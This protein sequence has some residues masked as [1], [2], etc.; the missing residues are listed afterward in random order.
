M[1]S[2]NFWLWTAAA[3]VLLLLAAS[4][5]GDTTP[6]PTLDAKQK[7]THSFEFRPGVIVDPDRPAVYLMNPQRGIDA[8]DLSSGKLICTTA[9]AAKPLFLYGDLL[10]AQAETS[11]RRGVLRI[12][13]LDAK[14]KGGLG[15]EAEIALP[16]GVWASIDDGLGTSFWASARIHEGAL[17]VSWFFA[18]QLLSGANLRPDATAPRQIT[19]AARIDLKTGR[20]ERLKADEL[21]PL[22]IAALPGNVAQLVASGVL[23]GPVWHVGGVAATIQRASDTGGQ[24]TIL[25]RWNLDTGEPLP[26]VVLFG[27]ELTFRYPSAN[28][29]H[30]LTSKLV[31]TDP[32]VKYLWVIFSLETGGRVAEVR[33]HSPAAWF[34]VSGSRLIYESPLQRRLVDGA[35]AEE[36]RKL[37]AIDLVSG[38]EL[39]N[40]PIRDTAYRGPYPP[41]GP[42]SRG[43]PRR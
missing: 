16:E 27:R 36:P 1:Q 8:V 19:G 26:D 12:V 13:I 37:R 35:W 25:R 5:N 43:T 20:V 22:P 4:A 29:R 30:L 34:F 31:E 11:D 15:L 39:W 41:V 21:P 28:G 38:A 17:I 10:V 2:I 6:Q 40:W 23:A 7:T 33:N 9:K 14:D 42:G 18:E 32:H 3:A 24:R